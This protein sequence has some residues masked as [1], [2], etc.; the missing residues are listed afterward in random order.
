[1]IELYHNI[2]WSKYKA[3]VFSCLYNIASEKNSNIRFFQIAETDADRITLSGVDMSYHT[4]PF[5]L[6]FK[7]SYAAIPT[8][9][10]VSKLFSSVWHSDAD[11][12][13]LPGYHRPEY[14]AMLLAAAKPSKAV[15]RPR[16]RTMRLNGA[17]TLEM[18]AICEGL[19]CKDM[20]V[21]LL[22]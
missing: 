14:W 18:S 15:A 8:S 13:L 12:I 1:M 9:R 7:G 17:G 5:E 6:M 21:C 20:A 2:L 4:Y 16:A 3:R 10:L 22:K 11:L 19:T